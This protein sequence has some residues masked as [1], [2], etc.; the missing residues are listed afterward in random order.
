MSKLLS[1]YINSN[2]VLE[3]DKKERQPGKLH[4]FLTNMDLDM[5]EG[6]EIN[7]EMIN[8]LDKMQCANYVAMSLLYGIENKSEGMISVTC[9]YLG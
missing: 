1:V 4:Q 8:S 7:G 6:I 2:K 5:D 3:F 9:G